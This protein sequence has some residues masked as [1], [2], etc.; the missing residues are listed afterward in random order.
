MEYK[1]KI[2]IEPK[3]LSCCQP[4]DLVYVM[5]KILKFI[6]RLFEKGYYL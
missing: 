6:I 3:P 1:M 5:S 4:R 2:K